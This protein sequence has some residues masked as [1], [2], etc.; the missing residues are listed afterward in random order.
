M[1]K[2]GAGPSLPLKE[3]LLG[4]NFVGYVF[5]GTPKVEGP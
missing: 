2:G 3:F 4:G 5:M 1:I